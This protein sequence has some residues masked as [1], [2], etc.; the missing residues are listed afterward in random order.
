MY[1][2]SLKR[3]RKIDIVPTKKEVPNKDSTT[4]KR[5]ILF[6]STAKGKPSTTK[7]DE[8]LMETK[9]THTVVS[10]GKLS[11][12]VKVDEKKN[13]HTVANKQKKD[14][15]KLEK[16]EGGQNKRKSLSLKG[17]RGGVLLN[18]ANNQND[19]ET[20]SKTAKATSIFSNKTNVR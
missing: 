18:A 1:F 12:V 15:P 20:K 8:K 17:S 10:K 9:T 11:T 19:A 3:A 13:G 6:S 2:Q 14:E 16:I 7:I 5:P 4:V